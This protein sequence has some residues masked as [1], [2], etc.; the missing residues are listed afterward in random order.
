[1][2]EKVKPVLVNLAEEEGWKAYDHISQVDNLYDSAWDSY[3][4]IRQSDGRGWIEDI[5][6]SKAARSVHDWSPK[7]VRFDA[8]Q[9]EILFQGLKDN[10]LEKTKQLVVDA[11]VW[12]FE[13]A[14][15]PTDVDIDD[16][17][18]KTGELMLDSA[19]DIGLW[20]PL[21]ESVS[22]W[23]EE[24]IL[25]DLADSVRYE[26]EA[27]HY[28]R[29]LYF[30]TG[31]ESVKALLKAGGDNVDLGEL[32]YELKNFANEYVDKFFSVLE[33]EMRNV[34]IW[35]RVRFRWHWKSKL[36]D[37]ASVKEARNE[38]VEYLKGQIRAD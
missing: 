34:D 25:E 12:A 28:E 3:R 26:H 7:G 10:E 14:Y 20:A 1:M 27:D 6:G 35:N 8:D 18:S 2:P 11:M 37:S 23:T 31:S 5:V 30:F 17:L 16:A 36:E 21:L 4:A 38:M 24:K 33:K 9:F 22:G 29:Y 32:N 13:E 15:T 19:L